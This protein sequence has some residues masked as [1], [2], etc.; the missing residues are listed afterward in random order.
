MPT[1]FPKK[2]EPKWQ[3]FWLANKTFRVVED[4]AKP[5]YYI[6]DMFPYPSGD[7]LHVGH[8]E[9]YTATDILARYKR[10]KGFNVLH[11]MGWDAFGL[12]AE[13]YAVETG[14]HPRETTARNVNNFRRQIQML[15]FS[16]DWDREVNTTDPDYY[17]WTQWIFLQ[18]F[19]TWYDPEVRR[20]RPI[21]EL[22]IPDAITSAGEEKVREFR[23]SKRLAY[24][25]EV[26]VNWCQA[27]GTVLANEEVIDGKSERGSHP[28]VR[29]PMRQWMLRITQYGERLLED[30]KLVDW[31]DA[32]KEM[33]R[34]WIGRSEGAEVDFPLAAASSNEAWFTQR[35]NAGFPEVPEETV[36]RVYTTRPDTLFGATYMV[37]APEHPLVAAITTREQQAAVDAYR[38]QAARK[39]DF[40]RTEMA[41]DKTGVFTGGYA[42][43]PVNGEKIPIWISDYVLMG[44]GTGAIMAVPAHDERDYAF[45]K[46]FGLPI[47][48][49]V[50]APEGTKVAPGALFSGEGTSIASGPITGMPTA[51]AKKTIIAWLNERGL[52]RLAVNFKLRDWLF[53]RQ[54]YWGEPFPILLE[55]GTGLPVDVDEA[56]LP[57]ALPELSDFKPTGTP[58]PPLSKAKDWLS[59]TRDG[60]TYRRETNTMPQWAGS[61]WYYLRYMDPKNNEKGWAPE[62]EQYWMPVDLYVGGAEH[63]VLHLLYSRFWHKVLY[64]LG[65]VHTAEPFQ[66]LV[67]Q[68]MILGEMEFM[69]YRLADSTEESPTWITCEQVG[70]HETLDRIDRQT[71][72]Q[73]LGIKLTENDVTKIGNDWVLTADNKIRVDAR[74]FKM[75]KSRKN[76]INPDEVVKDYGADSLRLYEMFMGPL[77]ATKPWN[78]KGVDGVWRFLNRV[79]RVIV[80][81]ASEELKLAAAVVD[82]EPTREQLQVMHRTIRGVGEDIEGLRFNTAI[83]KMMEYVN[84]LSP[85]TE[86]SKTLLDPLVLLL[87]PFAPHIAEELWQLLGHETTLAYEPWPTFDPALCEQDEIEVALQINNKVKAKIVVS[88]RLDN[89]ALLAAAKED[90]RIQAAVAGKQIIKEFVVNSNKGKLVNFVVKG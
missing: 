66:R 22:P 25:A 85:L 58:E 81:D 89:E 51:E 50:Q 73:V 87:A 8:P 30:L 39:S 70:D 3:Q 37:M 68:G 57:V 78:M 47:I 6:L 32:I 71:G 62:K 14:T 35:Q 4:P 86:R 74:S 67:N 84:A 48:D 16:Y 46:Q 2:I 60:K 17:R 83:S 59:V 45:A 13:Q 20:G 7:G 69:G 40:D 61:C 82:A 41:K 64:D 49:V 53:S 65:H 42:I 38:E 36:L 21:S 63:A 23:D 24:V 28:V 54:R 31:P 55:E 52:G 27:L 90:D 19:N 12:P 26:P 29:L 43:N 80:D 44:Y 77:E 11:P 56:D 10:M 33:Q 76:V 88:A 5:K 34:N 79:W 15:G 72:K 18:L 9:G 75:S 1:Y